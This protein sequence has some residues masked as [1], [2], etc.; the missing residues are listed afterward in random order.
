MMEDRSLYTLEDIQNP[1]IPQRADPWIYRHFDGYYYFSA[2]VPE[3][4]RIE[5]R[6][7]RTL[8]DLSHAERTVIWRRHEQGEMSSYIWAPELHFIDGSWY[9]YFTAGHSDRMPGTSACTCFRAI[10]KI[11]WKAAGKREGE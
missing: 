8:K 9:I 1:L 5:I 7:S 2:T 6:R 4:D 3:Y 11:R 10:L